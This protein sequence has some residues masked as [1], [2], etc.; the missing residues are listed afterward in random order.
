MVEISDF[1][2]QIKVRLKIF[3]Y[4]QAWHP[5]TSLSTENDVIKKLFDFQ[6][7]RKD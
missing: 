6:I 3:G 1:E 5:M 4:T 7:I 2:L